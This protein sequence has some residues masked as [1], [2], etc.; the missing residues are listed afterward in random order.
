M[1]ISDNIMLGPAYG[2]GTAGNFTGS[3]PMELGVGPMGRI[4]LHDVVPLAANTTGL[5]AAQ[6]VGA[7]GNL[8][9]TAGTGVTTTTLA[10]GT[11][12]LVLDT[13]RCVDVVSSNAGDT[14]QTV[15]IYGYDQYGQAMSQV[16]TLNGTTRVPTLKAFKQVY[17]I[18]IS[19]A[20][21]GNISAGTTDTLGLPFRVTDLGYVTNCMFNQTAVT[22]NSTN[23]KVAVQTSPATT[24]TGD[25]RG[26]VAVSSSD[27]TKRLVMG[28]MI[29]A[30]GCGPNAT[31]VGAYGV[32]QA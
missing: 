10:D 2:A 5:A 21:A 16:V 31:R 1:Q 11:T 17:R 32:P 14:T 13:P 20:T 3:S 6:A 22:I 9:L 12:A 24:A 30:I 19:A 25:V 26:T 8:T 28:L 7:A 29:P 27:G 18:A 23:I 15:T 4:Y